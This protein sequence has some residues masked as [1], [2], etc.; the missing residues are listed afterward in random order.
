M[1]LGMTSANANP[2]TSLS[3]DDLSAILREPSRCIDLLMAWRWPD[4]VRCAH[5]GSRDAKRLSKR[6]AWQCRACRRQTRLTAG[7]ALHGT[8]LPLRHWLYAM[9]MVGQ[10]KQSISALQL[11]K[12]LQIGSY[13][14]A[15][16]LL[17]KVR[18]ALATPSDPLPEQPLAVHSE[19]LPLSLVRSCVPQRSP[20]A[21][22]AFY[23]DR[24]IMFFYGSRCDGRARRAGAVLIPSRK[25]LPEDIEELIRVSARA[26]PGAQT[27]AANFCTWIAGTFHGVSAKY[28][29]AYLGEY[30][31][32]L[33][34]RWDE[35]TLASQ[36]GRRLLASPHT[37]VAALR[38]RS[39]QARDDEP[40]PETP[41]SPDGASEPGS[42]L[43]DPTRDSTFDSSA[44]SSFDPSS[45]PSFDSAFDS[46]FVGSSD[47]SFAPS[48]EPA[49]D[50][51]TP[52]S[53]FEPPE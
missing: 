30:L 24:H 19:V 33:N 27:I 46:S 20:R 17:H 47:S 26:Q 28:L 8:H 3:H 44:D 10:R 23:F 41:W 37:T 9:W 2:I 52:A 5:C 31:F 53:C 40:T 49:D 7:T 1:F 6:C 48:R 43:L 21:P 51:S 42:K 50:A 22:P 14:S 45:K 25:G 29:G 4:G 38:R 18:C 13:E 32:R 34:R 36:V 11:K 39:T 15:W 16:A 12:E 35:A